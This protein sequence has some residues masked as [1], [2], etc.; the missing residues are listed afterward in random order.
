MFIDSLKTA[1][2][3]LLPGAYGSL[4]ENLTDRRLRRVTRV[5]EKKNG[6]VIQSGPFSGMTYMSQAICSTLVPK[7]LGSYEAELHGVFSEVFARNY[8]TLIDIGCAEGYYAVG[9]ALRLP[10][11]RVIAFDINERARNLCMRL[12]QANHVA[13]RVQVEGQC[14][15]ERLRSLIS[16]RT[17]IIC[18]CEGCEMELLNPELVPELGDSDLVLELHDMI[19]AGITPTM[20]ARFHATHEIT[21]IDAVERD[22]SEFPVLRTFGPLTQ[23]A[24]VAEFRGGP[25]QWAYM[26]AR[27]S[28][29]S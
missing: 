29:A 12:A 18:D 8:E 17:L 16:T 20:L 4:Q 23:R 27:A 25:M 28:Q 10:N 19:E 21:L 2:R 3:Q 26:R 5:I 1:L 13:D 11:A 15:H 14:S 6:L 22:P 9:S 7:L 24:A